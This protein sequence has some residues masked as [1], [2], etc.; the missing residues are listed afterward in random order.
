MNIDN[1]PS[2]NTEFPHDWNHSWGHSTLSS[3]CRD[4]VKQAS[5]R[6][7]VKYHCNHFY[8]FVKGSFFW[9]FVLT[10]LQFSIS[11]KAWG[12]CTSVCT[13]SMTNDKWSSHLVITALV[14][15]N[16]EGLWKGPD[17]DDWVEASLKVLFSWSVPGLWR[18]WWSM[19]GSWVVKALWCTWGKM[20]GLCDK[21]SYAG[22]DRKVY[23]NPCP[24]PKMPPMGIR[25][26]ERNHGAMEEGRL[27]R[28]MTFSL[29]SHVWLGACVSHTWEI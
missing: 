28:W 25:A 27:V 12:A 1:A 3:I 23:A 11:M 14:S 29:A 20:A 15:A 6:I 10:S 16:I 2:V 9:L 8:T 17:C 26:S 22:S 4:T 13:K 5:E 24:C 7:I 21:K 18:P 19:A